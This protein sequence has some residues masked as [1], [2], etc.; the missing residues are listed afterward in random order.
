M[1]SAGSSQPA[2]AGTHGPGPSHIFLCCSFTFADK[3]LLFITVGQVK[4][5]KL[6]EFPRVSCLEKELETGLLK[7]RFHTH[8]NCGEEKHEIATQHQ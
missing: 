4:K 1:L 7:P 2:L 5:S 3:P 8:A 6:R